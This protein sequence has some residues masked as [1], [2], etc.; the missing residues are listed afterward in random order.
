MS[1]VSMKLSPASA[2]IFPVQVLKRGVEIPNRLGDVVVGVCGRNIHPPIGN[3]LNIAPQGAQQKL[4]QQRSVVREGIAIVRKAWPRG[5]VECE[6][7]AESGDSQRRAMFS[8]QLPDRS[9]QA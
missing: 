7:R 1:A 6:R 5:E 8:T 3:H 2:S 9:H 4:T